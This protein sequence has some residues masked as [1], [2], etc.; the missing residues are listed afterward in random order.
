V[1]TLSPADNSKDVSPATSFVM[2][3]SRD[4]AAGT[5]MISVRKSADGTTVEDIDATKAVIEGAK[6]TFNLSK[7][8]ANKTDYYVIVPAGAVTNTEITKDAF[9]GI[10]NVYDWNFTTGEFLCEPIKVT[11]TLQKQMECSAE[12][13]VM[14]E[15]NYVGYVLTMN[16][17]VTQPGVKVL[18]PGTYTFVGTTNGNDCKSTASI[19]VK[20][21]PVTR[22]DEAVTYLDEAVHYVDAE[23]GTDTMLFAGVHAIKYPNGK[24][25]RTLTVTVTEIMRTPTIAEVQGTG[26]KSPLLDKMVQ[27][28]G[29]VSGV[30]PGEG[31]FIQDANAA[32]S[33]IWVEYSK[34]TYEG[35]QIGNGVSLIGEV[36]EVANVTSIVA[37]S[38]AFVPPVLVLAPVM[39]ANPS[40][41]KAEKYESVLVK[42]DGAR[43]S[44]PAAGTGEWTIYYLTSNSALVNDWLY[45]TVVVKDHY[46]DVAGIVNGRLDNY[47]LEPRIEPDVKDITV[48]TGINPVQGNEFKVYPNPFNDQI[49]I[50]NFDKLTRVVISNVAGQKVIDIEYPTR[51]IR[52][53]NLVSGIY[54][55]S[56]YTENGIAKT[57]RMIKR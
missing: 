50:D 55:I 6:L 7:L 54:V 36:A 32:W 47:K 5:G 44:A 29:T 51:E 24:C 3:F 23:S 27:I 41:L 12:V 39:L 43:A 20:T 42:V 31:F 38:V 52:T 46:Y 22:T 4:I 14:V 35:L 21:A 33:G 11:A 56:L 53:A 18:D 10:T 45:Y 30:A 13:N 19:T 26:D 48:L 28:D 17:V 15:T 2:T 49:T 1:I 57:E 37:D 9:K 16:G 8:L 25:V 34:A 40:D